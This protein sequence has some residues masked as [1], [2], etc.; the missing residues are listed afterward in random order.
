[1]DLKRCVIPSCPRVAAEGRRGL[2]LVCYSAA[3]KKVEAHETTW[4]KLAEK[5][6]C[7]DMSDNPFND[8][9]SRA[10]EGQ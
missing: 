10:M 3:K 6:L 4:E 8:A 9:Y 1:M 7:E 5:G 2:C